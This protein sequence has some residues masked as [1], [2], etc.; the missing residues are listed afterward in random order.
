MKDDDVEEGGLWVIW[1]MMI[2]MMVYQIKSKLK[3]DPNWKLIQINL[4]Y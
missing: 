1:E 4:L 2:S 3:K